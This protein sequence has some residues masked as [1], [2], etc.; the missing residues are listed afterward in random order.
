MTGW[1]LSAFAASSFA[2]VN[3]A[4]GSS[5]PGV[6]RPGQITR[7][8]LRTSGVNTGRRRRDPRVL[9]L[10]DEIAGH[11]ADC[12][13]RRA[14]ANSR[15][16]VGQRLSEDGPEAGQRQE[17]NKLGV[18]WFNASHNLEHY[19]NLVVYLRLKGI[20]PPSSERKPRWR[21][22]GYSFGQ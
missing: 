7:S 12:S 5:H 16:E 8:V 11:P 19:G 2:T 9:P 1:L 13:L 4:I 21:A 14:G 15:P 6:Q 3:T 22:A 18:L 20:V 10:E 17:R